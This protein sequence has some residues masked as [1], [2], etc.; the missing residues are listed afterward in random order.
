MRAS[1]MTKLILLLSIVTMASLAPMAF[2]LDGDSESGER[3]YLKRCVGCHGVDGDGLGP[4]SE[5]I[6][7]FQGGVVEECP[8]RV[9]AQI[10][11][12]NHLRGRAQRPKKR[13]AMAGMTGKMMI[14]TTQV[15]PKTGAGHGR[16]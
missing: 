11:A 14:V 10:L 3:I 7:G 5:R 12:G 4:G 8:G 13:I 1:E 15:S 2:S 6:V 16:K 9:L